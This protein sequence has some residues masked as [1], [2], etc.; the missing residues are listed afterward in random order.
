MSPT[1]LFPLTAAQ[2][3]IWLDQISHGDSPLYNVGGYVK[4]VGHVDLDLLHRA[5]EQ[6]VAAHD[7]L[8][9]V[10]LPGA[11]A[12]GLPMQRYADFIPVSMPLHDLRDHPERISAAQAL[13]REQMQRPYALDGSP[14]FRFCLV[15]A[16][17][18]QYWLGIQAHH[19]ILDG[20]G[21]GQLLK[22]LAEQYTA[23]CEGDSLDLQGPSYGDFITDDARYHDSPRYARD[24]AYW[25]DKYRDLPEPLLVSRYH[26]RRSTDPAP[27]HS[28]VLAFPAALHTRMNQFAER[29]GASAF[30]VLL[31]ALHV[32]FTRTAQRDDWVVGLPLLNRTGARFKA[33]LGHF[34]Q[35]SA[36]VGFHCAGHR[37]A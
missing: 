15:R 18:D 8:R 36:G 27:S 10:L 4:L 30:H 23:L 29:C 32:Y 25:L 21:F 11:G 17:E 3:D 31:A 12:D 33:T 6:L 14:L 13:I 1:D 24:K 35:V 28:C 16:D 20:W 37:S 7:A 19:L 22:S 26:N 5:F 9:T 34:A 2:R